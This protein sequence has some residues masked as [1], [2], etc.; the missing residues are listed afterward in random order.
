MGK[1]VFL[2]LH[3]SVRDNIY[4][5]FHGVESHSSTVVFLVWSNKK[6]N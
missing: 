2:I 4:H 1:G 5:P 3:I 6:D